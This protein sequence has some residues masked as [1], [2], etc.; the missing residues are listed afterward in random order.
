MIDTCET[1]SLAYSY[2][3]T[4]YCTSFFISSLVPIQWR[5]CQHA[6]V[7]SLNPHI[8]QLAGL[9]ADTSASVPRYCLGLPRTVNV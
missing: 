5:Q 1:C 9:S 4:K 7:L 2:I 6:L 8:A 3:A